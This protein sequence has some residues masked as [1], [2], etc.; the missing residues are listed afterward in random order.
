MQDP[1]VFHP[2]QIPACALHG[3]RVPAGQHEWVG[4]SALLAGARPEGGGA[5]GGSGFGSAGGSLRPAGAIV[6]HLGQ[7][8][9]SLLGVGL[10]SHLSWALPATKQLCPGKGGQVRSGM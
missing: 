3:E 10:S 7:Q 2:L 9:H 5:R 1:F 4:E 6:P 8:H